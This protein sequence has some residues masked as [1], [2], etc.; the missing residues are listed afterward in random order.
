MAQNAYLTL[1]GKKQ[2]NIV[3]P[4]TQ[5]GRE[6]S[7][8]VHAFDHSVVSPRDPASG[9]PTGKRM[10][11][12][13]NILKEI[14][15]TSPLLRTALVNNETITAFELKFWTLV[16]INGVEKQNYTIR[17]INASIASISE[18]MFD[19]EDPNLQKFPLRE[20]VS[21]TYQ[22]IEWIWVDGNVIASD[23]WEAVV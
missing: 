10:H 4:V 7:I 14:D 12:P 18:A 8:L 6:G 9:L 15:K 1:A 21:F 13:L 22:K 3:G 2:G 23:D 20:N 5:K 16:S 19:N 11:K 17:L